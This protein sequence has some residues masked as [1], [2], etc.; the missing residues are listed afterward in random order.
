MCGLFAAYS[1]K[2]E[3]VLEEIYLGLCALQHRGQLSAGVSWISEG[4]VH[5]KK[6][7]GLV[8]EALSQQELALI[9]ANAAIGHVRYD[10]S[11]NTGE[12][13]SEPIGADYAQGPVAI[14][15]NGS[16]TNAAALST[17]L[18]NCG[19]IFRTTSDAEIILQ[20]MAHQPKAVPLEAFET[21]LAKVT[22][23]Y[24]AVALFDG[25]L[26]AARDPWGFRPLAIGRKGDDYFV[27]SESCAFDIVG[28]EFVRD[29]EP[30]ETV[31]IDK[32]GLIS[33]RLPR[34]AERHRRCSFEYVYFAR[35]D[36]VIDGV[37]V[38]EARKR[39]GACL[40][41]HTE[42]PEN[43]VVAGLP[44][45][46]TIAA[47]GLAEKTGLPFESGII[48]N[49]YVGRTFIQPT[50]RVR[51]GGVKIKL[52]PQPGIFN[53]KEAV[54]VD[55]SI[56]RGTT[57]KKVIKLIRD[58]GATRVHIR[59]ASPPVKYPC[60]YGIDTP[61]CEELIASRMDTD[62]LCREIGADSLKYIDCDEL[63]NAIGLPR[64]ELCTACFDGTYLD[65]EEQQNLLE[66]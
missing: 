21:A 64:C 37:S 57:S 10:S 54:I 14:A 15:L 2:A 20:L 35:P 48:R 32:R 18:T 17:Y 56:V 61:S 11:A 50:Q 59:I 47:L 24:S 27:A 39:L 33:R 40:A 6:G 44:D 46:G 65:E 16:L 43:S 19:A 58:A 42:C 55:D 49:R 66:V 23:A 28:A 25:S 52:N 60:Y 9:D 3:R 22:G 36:S 29:V 4:S 30:G 7:M 62:E 34:T 13:N 31:V 38:Y 1:P 45:S 8:H 63:C 5:I 26:V 12:E 51:E 53:D 41:H